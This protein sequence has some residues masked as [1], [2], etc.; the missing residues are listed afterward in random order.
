MLDKPL[1]KPLD[2]FKDGAVRFYVDN[3]NYPDS[4]G[5]PEGMFV[6]PKADFEKMIARL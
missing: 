4:V 3:P 1:D 6:M 2:R 5:N